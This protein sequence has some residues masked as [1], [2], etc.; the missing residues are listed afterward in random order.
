MF[1]SRS[2]VKYT[3]LDLYH[4]FRK[5]N[6]NIDSSDYLKKRSTNTIMPVVGIVLYGNKI[7][8]FY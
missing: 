3:I 8:K 2:D 4:V 6:A 7:G 1:V 5:F